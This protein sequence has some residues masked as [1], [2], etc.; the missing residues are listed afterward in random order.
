MAVGLP[1]SPLA[2]ALAAARM[3]WRACLACAIRLAME[4]SGSWSSDEMIGS[5][6]ALEA[7]ALSIVLLALRIVAA[8]MRPASSDTGAERPLLVVEGT[9]GAS[10]PQTAQLRNLA[11]SP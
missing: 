6:S 7:N 5:R 3:A 4:V 11:S 1:V 10:V 9:E 8:W 2:L